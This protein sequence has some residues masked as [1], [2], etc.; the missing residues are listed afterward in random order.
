[1]IEIERKFL[2][3]SE[4]FKNE[5]LNKSEI[6]QGFLNSDKNRTVRIRIKDKQGFITVKGISSADGLERFEWE[7][8]IL[9]DEAISLLQLCEKPIIEKT[10]YEVDSGLHIFEVDVFYGENEGLVIAEVELASKD[11]SY[12]A[13]IWLGNEVTG[14]QRY[15]N[16]NLIANPFKKWKS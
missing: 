12:V 13:P 1:M 7:K 9:Y 14:D 6:K 2:V 16:S 10:R 11:E 15:Y 4:A 5:A 3:R 8:E